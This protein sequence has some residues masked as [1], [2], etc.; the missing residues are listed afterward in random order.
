MSAKDTKVTKIRV[1]VKLALARPLLSEVRQLIVGR[2]AAN[3]S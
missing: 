2:Q 1:P 3:H